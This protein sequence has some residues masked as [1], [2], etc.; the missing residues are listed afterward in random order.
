MKKYTNLTV[1]KNDEISSGI[2]DMFLK[3]DKLSEILPGQFVMLYVGLGEHILPRPI[4]ICDV[5]EPDNTIRLV[6]QVVGKGTKAF[7]ELNIGHKLK[8]IFPIGNGFTLESG[9][10][11]ALIGGGIGIPP[12][13]Y[14]A[15]LLKNLNPNAEITAFLGFRSDIYLVSDFE[16]LGVNVNVSTDDGSFGFKGNAVQNIGDEVFDYV[17]ACGPNPM[18]KAVADYAAKK[19]LNAQI[20]TEERMACGIGACV[21]CVVKMKDGSYK[22]SCVDGPVFDA[23]A[24]SFDE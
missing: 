22:K 8:A 17:Y 23:K 16:K 20:S 9:D 18:L 3:T 11:F 12:M 13:L 10:K 21:G 2:F 1:V 6:Y 7:S 14:T 24:V 19:Q 15:K 4:S 5:Y